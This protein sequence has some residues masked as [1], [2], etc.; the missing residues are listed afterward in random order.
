LMALI[1]Q[2]LINTD[3]LIYLEA[4]KELE[5]QLIQLANTLN[6]NVTAP[7]QATLKAVGFDCLKQTKVGQVV[8]GL[9]RLSSS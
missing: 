6:K 3:T 7:H 1:T 5:D 4:D 2:S 8:A 9:Y